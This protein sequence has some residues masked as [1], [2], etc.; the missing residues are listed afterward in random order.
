MSLDETLDRSE[1]RVDA[2]CK[3]IRDV[4]EGDNCKIILDQFFM[5]STVEQRCVLM[6]IMG[7]NET[8]NDER[9]IDLSKIASYG[10]Y[11][12]NKKIWSNKQKVGS[13]E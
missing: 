4:R 12:K 10:V 7:G 2:V 13:V 5:L 1:K 8:R 11:M 9:F 3:A 6:Y